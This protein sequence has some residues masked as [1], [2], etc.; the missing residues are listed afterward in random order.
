MIE[1]E[2]WMSIPKWMTNPLLHENFD[3]LSDSQ[4]Q[5]FQSMEKDIYLHFD[6]ARVEYSLL[7]DT[8]DTINL[9]KV[10]VYQ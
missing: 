4:L 7:D 5:E 9:I 10:T 6:G 8:P 3:N 1:E 2:F